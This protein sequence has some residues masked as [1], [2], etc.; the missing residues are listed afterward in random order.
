MAFV[1]RTELPCF[2]CMCRPPAGLGWFPRGRDWPVMIGFRDKKG[3]DATPDVGLGRIRFNDR[4][5]LNTCTCCAP[6]FTQGAYV[7]PWPWCG[8]GTFFQGPGY[9]ALPIRVVHS[10]WVPFGD[11]MTLTMPFSIWPNRWG[12]WKNAQVSTIGRKWEFVSTSSSLL[13]KH[14]NCRPNF[15]V[16][17]K[18]VGYLL[19]RGRLRVEIVL[20]THRRILPL[21]HIQWTT[22][23]LI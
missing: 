4:F 2:S 6:A 1:S 18:S 22:G 13:S 8:P 3:L 5:S 20:I 11:W 19:I 15:E 9:Q 12:L 21:N 14:V 7:D 17:G 10:V 23:R 16:N